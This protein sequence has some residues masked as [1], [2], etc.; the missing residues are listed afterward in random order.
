MIWSICREKKSPSCRLVNNVLITTPS[1][2]ITII[3]ANLE[4]GGTKE[5]PSYN[6]VS[7]R[8]QPDTNYEFS[9]LVDR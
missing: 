7:D 8:V 4:V 9:N 5:K 2:G 1:F 6:L 3:S